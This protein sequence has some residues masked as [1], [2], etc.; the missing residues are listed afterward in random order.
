MNKNKD[1]NPEV[2][3]SL[4]IKQPISDPI[5][6]TPIV[7][8][9]TVNEKITKL[10]L[11][12]GDWVSFIIYLVVTLLIT[13]AVSS[14]IEFIRLIIIN[15]LSKRIFKQELLQ[16]YGIYIQPLLTAFLLLIVGLI[17]YYSS[18]WIYVNDSNHVELIK[19][20]I[21]FVLLIMITIIVLFFVYHLNNKKQKTKLF[22]KTYKFGYRI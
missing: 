7:T 1:K 8:N 22:K 12:T 13:S 16:K 11:P 2:N 3:P 19:W 6:T 15:V 17:I 20:V 4:K 10:V 14:I 5:N 18:R 21:Y 9:K